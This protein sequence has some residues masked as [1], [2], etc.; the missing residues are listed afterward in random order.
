M[1]RFA[2]LLS[3]CATQAA[4]AQGS[5]T[6]T[7]RGLT[8]PRVTLRIDGGP[9]DRTLL[10]SGTLG[11]GYGFR[12]EGRNDP[13]DVTAF[14]G[15]GVALAPADR[16]EF[17]VLAIPLRLTDDAA[18]LDMELYFRGVF[19]RARRVEIGGQLLVQVPTFDDFGIGIGVPMLFRLHQRVRLDIGVELELVL[20]DDPA[21][22][23]DDDLQPNLDMP[24][25][26]YVNV[27]P[28]FYF[29][30]RGG[31]TLYDVDVIEVPIGGL[32]GFTVGGR[33]ILGDFTAAFTWFAG[34]TARD[35]EIV[36]G[37]T[38]RFGL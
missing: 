24:I 31:F 12:L 33:R 1:K 4:S 20:E 36:F 26:L 32:V 6:W 11:R 13:D 2:I 25:A 14:M 22:P 19:F 17:G 38:A 7:E 15:I 37:A 29:G 10:D 35:W 23:G 34:E 18:Y 16:F 3:F 30:F 27:T 5:P 8:D 28:R 21:S 9:P